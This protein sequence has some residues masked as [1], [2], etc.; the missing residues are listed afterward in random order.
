MMKNRF[1]MHPF[2]LVYILQMNSNIDIHTISFN[3]FGFGYSTLYFHPYL[4]NKDFFASQIRIT[5][6]AKYT[7]F[8]LCALSLSFRIFHQV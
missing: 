6:K 4:S 8:E 5:A 1:K 7:L 3:G 2:N